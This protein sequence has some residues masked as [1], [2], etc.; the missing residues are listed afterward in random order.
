MKFRIGKI[1]HHQTVMLEMLSYIDRY[2][3]LQ[4]VW[5]TSNLSRQYMC[6]VFNMGL[7]KRHPKIEKLINREFKKTEIMLQD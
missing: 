7:N 1:T 6:K 5:S 4:L 2:P 3:R